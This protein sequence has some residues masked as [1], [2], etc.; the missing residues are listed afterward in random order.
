MKEPGICPSCG[1]NRVA[2]KDSRQMPASTTYR[3]K[4]C[5]ECKHRYSSTSRTFYTHEGVEVTLETN[6]SGRH[7]SALRLERMWERLKAALFI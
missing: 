4:H 5:R 2:I 7:Q 3:R 1:S 6:G